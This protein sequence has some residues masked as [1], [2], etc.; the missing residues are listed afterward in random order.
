MLSPLFPCPCW[1]LGPQRP[2]HLSPQLL[3]MPEEHLQHYSF[4]SKLCHRLLGGASSNIQGK[5]CVFLNNASSHNNSWL[6][7]RSALDCWRLKA[8]LLLSPLS[9]GEASW[10]T[11]PRGA[12]K[13]STLPKLLLLSPIRLGEKRHSGRRS[14]LQ[15]R[16]EQ[17]TTKRRGK[18]RWEAMSRL[19][20]QTMQGAE[21]TVT[22]RGSTSLPQ[23]ARAHA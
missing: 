8:S 21:T 1:P 12:Y 11:L 13:S 3:P 15:Q 17:D 9:R 16:Q 22:V 14:K 7:S 4:T 5:A 6:R 23:H 10:H 2:F 18:A 19:G 20:T